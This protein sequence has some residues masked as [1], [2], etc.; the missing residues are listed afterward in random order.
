MDLSELLQERG[1]GGETERSGAAKFGRSTP[2]DAN[3]ALSSADVCGSSICCVCHWRRFDSPVELVSGVSP[4]RFRYHCPTL[5]PVSRRAVETVTLSKVLWTGTQVPSCQ[6]TNCQV[7]G[8][9]LTPTEGNTATTTRLRT[10]NKVCR[11]RVR[12]VINKDA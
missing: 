7:F 9:P 11:H 8:T 2:P 4:S 5:P 1:R 6:H 10:P 12:A 3:D